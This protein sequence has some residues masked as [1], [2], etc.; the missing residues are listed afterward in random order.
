MSPADC[1]SEVLRSVVEK[2]AVGVNLL[3]LEKR[4][5]TTMQ[6]LGAVSA[7]KGYKPEWA[8]V[9][10][11]SSLCLG[12]NDIIS[13]PIP[14]DYQLKDGDLLHIDCGVIIDGWC[15]DAGL[16]IPIGT[17]S[18]QDERLLRYAKRA[19]YEGIRQVKP[20]I[21]VTE[22]GR[23]IERYAGRMGYVVNKVFYG[24]GIGKTMHEGLQIPHFDV[25]PQE[26]KIEVKPGKYRYEYHEPENIPTLVEGDVICIEPMLTYK[27]PIGMRDNDGWTVRTRDG[28]KSCFFEHMVRVTNLGHEVLTTHIKEVI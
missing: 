25:P 11:P 20:G 6:L 5:E 23:A 1:V 22:I 8:P 2:A 28:R 16:T 13:H 7:D 3:D 12:V 14:R 27:D 21:K 9:P 10:F 26:K 4:A 17:V 18:N 15:G 19:L 24:H